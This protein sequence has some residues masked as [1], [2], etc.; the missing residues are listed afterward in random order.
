MFRQ[1]CSQ[2]FRQYC[3]KNHTG[4]SLRQRP[5]AMAKDDSFTK[6][7]L[8]ICILLS[9]LG[10]QDRHLPLCYGKIFYL[11]SKKPFLTRNYW[12]WVL[13]TT[14]FLKK[15]TKYRDD[16]SREINFCYFGNR[17]YTASRFPSNRIP[18]SQKARW[19]GLAIWKHVYSNWINFWRHCVSR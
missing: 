15:T 13:M 7:R 8:I 1:Y 18:T 16:S 14:K 3:Y 10:I 5:N 19:K 12:N 11:I 17:P 4:F 2:M 6:W 9:A